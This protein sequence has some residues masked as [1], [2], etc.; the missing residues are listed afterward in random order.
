MYRALAEA[1]GGTRGSP[2][3]ASRQHSH[4]QHHPQIAI[5][6]TFMRGHSRL[7][8]IRQNSEAARARR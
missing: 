1:A 7:S 4:K 2:N 8:Q 3:E 5:S 6:N